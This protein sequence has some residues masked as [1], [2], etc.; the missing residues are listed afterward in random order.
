[1]TWEVDADLASSALTA[2]LQFF[3]VIGGDDTA[4]GRNLVTDS[5][6]IVEKSA[7]YGSDEL[8]VYGEVTGG[9]AGYLNIITGPAVIN[10]SSGDYTMA[11]VFTQTSAT[12]PDWATILKWVDSGGGTPFRLGKQAGGTTTYF[13]AA[14]AV[15]LAYNLAAITL[16][17]EW[18]L[19]VK[20][21]SGTTK[22]FYPGGNLTTGAQTPNTG[23]MQTVLLGNE[24]TGFAGSYPA[25]F[26]AVGYWDA[27]LS[28]SDCES[29][30]T[31][32]Q[33][34]LAEAASGPALPVLL[35]HLRSQGIA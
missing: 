17:T 2:D 6:Y 3:F 4:T 8:G 25:R 16:S 1:M 5:V 27:A 18:T 24:T 26:R 9:A 15:E 19:V 20:R 30:V 28:D 23:Q 31:T 7:S 10:F 29:I 21:A 35:H 22:L 13:Q 32:P 33:Q 11:V 14:T 12:I 34:L